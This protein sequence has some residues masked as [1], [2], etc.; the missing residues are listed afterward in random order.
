M[1]RSRKHTLRRA[2]SAS[3]AVR[4]VPSK[5]ALAGLLKSGSGAHNGSQRAQARKE[6]KRV[7]QQLRRDG[8][9]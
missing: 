5:V 8:D 1:S 3:D 6:R 4:R 7:K 9:L 2:E